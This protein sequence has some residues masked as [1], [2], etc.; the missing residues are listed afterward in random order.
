MHLK[1][2]QFV[3]AALIS[4]LGLGGCA[5]ARSSRVNES[6]LISS[7]A[8]ASALRAAADNWARAADERDARTM[9]QYFADDIYAMYPRNAPVRGAAANEAGWTRTFAHSGVTHPIAIDT[10]IVA[11][12][13]DLGYTLGRWHLT[14]P[15]GTMARD[16]QD[17]GG[18]FVAIW[19]AL[20]P[21]GAWRLV[22]LSANEHAPAPAM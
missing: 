10:V 5:V 20:G 3:F 1:P 12:S 16:P 18:R 4:V 13:G 21:S 19:R 6:G 7:A 14:A 8:A 11:A 15:A 22:M 9:S 17:V 2:C